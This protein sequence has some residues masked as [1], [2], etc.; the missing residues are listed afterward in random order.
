MSAR[1]EPEHWDSTT[2]QLPSEFPP[3]VKHRP[4]P[5]CRGRTTG[6]GPSAKQSCSRPLRLRAL[7]NPTS[8]TL[9]AGLFLVAPGC[10]SFAFYS[11]PANGGR[12]CSGLGYDFQLCNTQDCPDSLADFREEQCRQ[13]DLYFEHGDAQHHW[14][15]HEHR[16]GEPQSRGWSECPEDR[17]VGGLGSWCPVPLIL[18]G[19]DFWQRTYQQ[20]PP[21]WCGCWGPPGWKLG[22]PGRTAVPEVPENSLAK[23]AGEG[24][25]VGRTGECLVWLSPPGG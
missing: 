3:W 25:G 9:S 18:C 23:D 6:L 5:G 21:W 11:S 16:D 19:Q 12:T 17:S 7:P 20:S 15:P 13:W 10:M 2:S 4:G 14:L 22:A 24:A 8:G 1:E